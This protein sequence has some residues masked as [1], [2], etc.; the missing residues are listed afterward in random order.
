MRIVV[1][2]LL[3]LAVWVVW[4]VYT[5]GRRVPNAYERLA[6]Q[7]K[8]QWR[9]RK[10]TTRET[11]YVAED[12]DGDGTVDRIYPE[13]NP[14]AGFARPRPEGADARWLIVCL[15]GIP[16]GELKALWE[17]GYFREFFAPS[18]LISPLP[19]DSESAL[20]DVFHAAPVPGY[21]HRYFDR[22]Q[23]RLQGGTASTV[24]EEDIPYLHL[25]DYDMGG[26]LKGL[27]YI[28]PRKSYRADLSRLR[29]QFL[30]S[31]EK[32]F[33]AHIA[34]SD[35]L[36]HI[37]SRKEMRELLCEADSLLRELYFRSEGK[38][39]ITVFSDH[40]NSLVP[41][42]PVPLRRFLK[43][44]GWQLTAS[45]RG[46][47]DVVVPAY[48]LVGFVAVYCQ[49]QNVGELARSL[50][51]MGGVD[52]AVYAKAGSV[53]IESGRGWARIFW[54]PESPASG[55]APKQF[56]Y[57]TL[58]GDP[59]ELKPILAALERAGKLQPNGYLADADLFAATAA[60][61]YP[62]PGYRLWQ[63]AT[64]HVR[65][66]ADILLSLKPGYHYGCRSF[67]H[68]VT[69]LSTHG[70]FDRAQSVGFAMSTA[71]PLPAVL[72]SRDLLPATL[73]EDKQLAQASRKTKS[74]K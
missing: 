72:R 27:T 6:G 25:L 44:N 24:S 60:H 41:S 65:N 56:C 12:T 70:G 11:I 74:K 43:E 21:E 49:P 20:T 1:L 33:L 51:E 55:D 34:A 15:D 14:Q 61:H 68:M 32:V 31:E 40:G 19:S 9:Y 71:G 38:L 23:N 17:E 36:Y 53:T 66:R 37:L 57:Q 3:A 64:N 39:R 45:L 54:L 26:V 69:L 59:L 62:D 63:W 73:V 35:S 13:T 22:R 58:T 46:P 48:G 2:L 29:R 50:A 7:R 10:A 52:F 42:Q 30:H 28:L 5:W 16:Y 47:R 4:R 18:E 67:D 8:N